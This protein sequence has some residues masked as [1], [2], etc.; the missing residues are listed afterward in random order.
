MDVGV[1]VGDAFRVGAGDTVG[2]GVVSVSCMLQAERVVYK[3]NAVDAIR[4]IRRTVFIRMFN[5]IKGF[6]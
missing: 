6:S 4:I 1:G 2:I 3:K 5:P